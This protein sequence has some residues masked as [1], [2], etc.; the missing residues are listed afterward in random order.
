MESGMAE[1]IP[2]SPMS[3]WPLREAFQAICK[4]C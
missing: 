3:H 2:K 1:H 4:L